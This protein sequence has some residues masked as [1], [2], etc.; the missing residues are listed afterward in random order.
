ML[1]CSLL[2]WSYGITREASV[3]FSANRWDHVVFYSNF[4]NDNTLLIQWFTEFL[5][6]IF[7][8]FSL[9]FSGNLY[10]CIQVGLLKHYFVFRYSMF[11]RNNSVL[12]GSCNRTVFILD[13]F[14]GWIGIFWSKLRSK[15]HTFGKQ[16]IRECYLMEIW[17]SLGESS[18]AN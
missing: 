7:L 9:S 14:Y 8:V 15:L 5:N 6:I 2:F 16:K 13:I 4:L 18:S 17:H 1:D 12:P 10:W 3:F 11:S